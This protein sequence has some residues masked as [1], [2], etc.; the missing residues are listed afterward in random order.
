MLF[1]V[2]NAIS[3]KRL[4]QLSPCDPFCGRHF[5]TPYIVLL[6]SFMEVIKKKEIV[7]TYLNKDISFYAAGLKIQVTC[8]MWPIVSATKDWLMSN[9]SGWAI[10]CKTITINWPPSTHKCLQVLML[11]AYVLRYYIGLSFKVI[12]HYI[13]IRLLTSLYTFKL[14]SFPA[15]IYI[16]HCFRIRSRCLNTKAFTVKNKAMG[17]GSVMPLL[18]IRYRF[19]YKHL[20][21][22]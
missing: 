11:L 9:R 12:I 17:G 14:F 5:K 21:A 15:I 8:G 6:C 18:R 20:L 13:F 22:W 4:F 10:L 2:S 1:C 16:Y 7:E 3:C 19:F